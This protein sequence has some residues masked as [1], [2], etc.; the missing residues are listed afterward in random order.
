MRLLRFFLIA[1]AALCARTASAQ[2]LVLN[3]YDNYDPGFYCGAYGG[4]KDLIWIANPTGTSA[5]ATVTLEGSE[6]QVTVPAYNIAVVT[7]PG[8]VGGP[9]FITGPSGG[10]L[11]ASQEVFFTED[12]LIGSEVNAVPA[13]AASSE[14]V[15][16]WYDQYDSGFTQDNVQLANPGSSAAEV[17][18]TLYTATGESTKTVVVPAKGAAYVNFAGL[19]GGPVKISA[20]EYG[21][22]VGKVLASRR[23]IYYSSFNETNA[24]PIASASTSAVL[25]WYDQYDQGFTLDNITVVNTNDVD[26]ADVTVK[27]ES[28]GVQNALDLHPYGEVDSAGYTNFPGHVGGPVLISSNTNILA[29]ART[30][31]EES[32]QSFNEVN[33]VPTS[34]ASENLV[35]T[36]YDGS[37]L[38]ENIMVAN[39][40]CNTVTGTVTV[41]DNG[42]NSKSFSLGCY[43]VT[44]ISFPSLEGPAV[45]KASSPVVATKRT[46]AYG[47]SEGEWFME[48]SAI[49]VP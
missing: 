30:I 31:F 27:V 35:F 39:P 45:V 13:S 22:V 32:I 19:T 44:A 5:D 1:C 14:L 6:Q 33:A 34:A 46:I 26:D 29:S 3:W 25:P 49:A 42:S 41:Y 9:V 40:A 20:V 11:T 37:N 28:A 18:V 43:G 12:N 4:C 47:F 21:G 38:S 48:V 17:S 10:S 15:L 8:M 2:Q 36:F 16:N 23:T 24:V 7:F